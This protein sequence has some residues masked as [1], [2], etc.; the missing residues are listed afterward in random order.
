MPKVLILG[1]GASYGHGA[2]VDLRPPLGNGFFAASIPEAVSSRYK[3]LK[4]YVLSVL[5]LESEAIEQFD[6][7]E[8]Y[9]RVEA[10]WWLADSKGDLLKEVADKPQKKLLVALGIPTVLTTYIYHVISFCTQWLLEGKICPYHERIAQTWL[11]PGDTI[12]NFN[13]DQ[14]MR[15]S[16]EDSKTIETVQLIHPHG[17]ARPSAE[18]QDPLTQFGDPSSFIQ[19]LM[20]HDIDEILKGKSEDTPSELADKLINYVSPMFRNTSTTKFVN[21]STT[22]IFAVDNNRHTI[23]DYRSKIEQFFSSYND[24]HTKLCILYADESNRIISPS[25]YKSLTNMKT[26][27]GK[28]VHAL[29]SADQALACGF[30]F[31]DAHFNEVL[32]QAMR[33]RIS[34]LE[35]TIVT[36]DKPAFKKIQAEFRGTRVR[37]ILYD[38]WLEQFAAECT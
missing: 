37:V 3:E 28:V 32:R 27:W 18:I 26:K 8:L 25:P 38:G 9:G 11:A 16:L 34:D 23:Y 33:N 35:L 20:L 24:Y 17:E 36:R 5:C 7:E 12:I 29:S 21:T 2:Q 1:A 10:S 22:N 4:Q 30:S 13:Y 19:E 31:R 6:I 15:R 14:I